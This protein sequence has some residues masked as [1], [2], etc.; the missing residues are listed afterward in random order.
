MPGVEYS[1]GG[2]KYAWCGVFIKGLEVCLVWSIH[3]VL[4]I[5]KGG[6][7]STLLN[8]WPEQLNGYNT[9]LAAGRTLDQISVECV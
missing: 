5:N 8:V 3:W 4:V 9:R 7:N 1:M 6:G 2:W